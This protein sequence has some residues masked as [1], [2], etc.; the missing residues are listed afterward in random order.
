MH[1]FPDKCSHA[2]KDVTWSTFKSAV[3]DGPTLLCS[4]VTL[5]VSCLSAF[6]TDSTSLMPFVP[7]API[8]SYT[9]D[10]WWE[11]DSWF[12][13]PKQD[14]KKRKQTEGQQQ[15]S[16]LW[17]LGSIFHGEGS[18]TVEQ[19]AQRGCVGSTF[20]DTQSP[21]GQGL[22]QAALGNSALSTCGFQPQLFHVWF[23]FPFQSAPIQPTKK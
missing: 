9:R 12:G 13:V 1:V 22:E 17:I 19:V 6:P 3:L 23:P 7:A 18:Q 15:F 21:T 8:L 16:S 11:T 2:S 5:S 14:R 10:L 20:G 4:S